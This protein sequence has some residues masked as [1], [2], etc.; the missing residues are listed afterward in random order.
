MFQCAGLAKAYGRQLVLSDFSYTFQE[1]GFYVLLGE[2]GSGKTTFLNLLAG[3]LPFDAG[4]ISVNG[5][6]FENQVDRGATENKV[7]Y[8]TQDPFFVDSLTVQDN[9]RLIRD[10]SNEISRVLAEVGL[11]EKAAQMPTTLSG[12][13]KQRLAI[14]RALIGGK[15]VLLLDEPTAALDQG[16]KLAVFQMLQKLKNRVLIICST[17]DAQTM[18]YADEVI[19]FQKARAVSAL[20]PGCAKQSAVIKEQRKGKKDNLNYYLKQWFRSRYHNRTSDLL[21]VC[22]LILAMMLCI[23][24]DIPGHKEEATVRDYYRMNMLGIQTLGDTPWQALGLDESGVVERVLDYSGSCPDGNEDLPMDVVMRPSPAY[25]L[26]L[27][28]LPSRKEAFPLSDALAYGSYFTDT[29]QIILSWEMANA[30]NPYDPAA[31]LGEKLRISVYSYGGVEFEIVGIFHQFTDSEKKYLQAL[32]IYIQEDEEYDPE[33]YT[34]LYFINAAFTRQ[35]EDDSSF[36]RGNT[37]QRRYQLFFDSYGEMKDYYEKHKSQLEE[38]D[39]VMVEY[40]T[41]RLMLEGSFTFSFYTTLP[42]TVFLAVFSIAFFVALK[43]TEFLHNSRFVGVFEYAGYDKA[44]VVNRFITLNILKMAQQALLA[45]LIALGLTAL[46]N[47]LNLRYGFVNF[48]IFSY[49]P[50]MIALCLLMILAASWLLCNMMLR[51]VQVQS[52]Y[53][54]LIDTRDLI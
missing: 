18:D 36:F 24:S 5:Q 44:A 14:A 25:E 45:L 46:I 29:N 9:L 35:L 23:Y 2:S 38:N 50:G 17:H 26:T 22:F 13:E 7:D 54:T 15:R 47:G 32:D 28:T 33:N 42:V 41:Y 34:N 20:S 19:C 16:N 31:L 53:E 30:M 21:F 4:T 11:Q 12:G 27:P 48:Q 43:K 52:W 10:D 39:N 40:C 1:R 51:K 37:G 3:L 8:I 6:I 49:N